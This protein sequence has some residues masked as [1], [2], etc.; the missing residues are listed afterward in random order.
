MDGFSMMEV[1]TF[2]T[3]VLVGVGV[4][5]HILV[6]KNDGPE[7]KHWSIGALMIWY[8]VVFVGGFLT[9]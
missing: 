5:L 6:L 3:V 9:S 4:V 7:E 2:A 1:G 8:A